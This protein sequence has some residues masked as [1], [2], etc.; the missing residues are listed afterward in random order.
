MYDEEVA[1]VSGS[2]ALREIAEA[3]REVPFEHRPERLQLALARLIPLE[4]PFGTTAAAPAAPSPP[5]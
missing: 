5:D 4:S 3:A 2:W 1:G